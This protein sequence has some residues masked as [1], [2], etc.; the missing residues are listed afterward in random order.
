MVTH[1]FDGLTVHIAE[2]NSEILL[3]GRFSYPLFCRNLF[4]FGG[5]RIGSRVRQNYQPLEP[6]TG[7]LV[8]FLPTAKLVTELRSSSH[9][10][11]FGPEFGTGRRQDY[12]SHSLISPR[13]VPLPTRS[14]DSIETMP[15]PGTRSRNLAMRICQR[16]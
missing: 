5:V 2:H 3:I 11:R 12:E 7:L 13:S 4:G 1:I 14:I 8:Q 9:G 15:P 6:W 16:A 10:I